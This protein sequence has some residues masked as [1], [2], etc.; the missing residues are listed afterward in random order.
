MKPGA[1][2]SKVEWNKDDQVGVLVGEGNYLYVAQADGATTTLTTSATDVP[3]EGT[4]YAVYPYD[5]NA[6]LS[7]GVITTTLPSEQTAVLGSF[8]THLAVASTTESTLAF[9][10]V[11][12][13]VKVTIDADNVSKIVF[14]G[15]SDEIVSGGINVT[16]SDAPAWTEAEGLGAKSV[17]LAP[18][19]G[20][21]AKGSYYFAVLP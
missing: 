2:E 6:T 8:S 1:D 18:V 10:N 17:T 12:G 4:F 21:L 14:E 9:K 11:C 13:L 20:N 5:E 7:E 15:N 16:V 19:S 3:T